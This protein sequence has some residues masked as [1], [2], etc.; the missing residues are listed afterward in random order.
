MSKAYVAILILLGVSIANAVVMVVLSHFLSPFRPTPVKTAAYESGM[1]PI[2]DA[3][4]RFSV[5]FYLVAILFIVFDI[6]TI[7]LIPW[8]VQFRQLGVFGFVEMLV[9]MGV[10]LVGFIYIWKKGALQWD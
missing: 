1:T 3:R 7:F 9:F 4:E 10:L 5:K 2:T 6:E 8:G